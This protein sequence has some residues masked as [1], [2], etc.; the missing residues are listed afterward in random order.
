MTSLKSLKKTI[1]TIQTSCISGVIH[2]GCSATGAT[3]KT[4]IVTNMIMNDY[5]H[6]YEWGILQKTNLL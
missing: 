4:C 2:A 5:S 3:Q 6:S 1:Q